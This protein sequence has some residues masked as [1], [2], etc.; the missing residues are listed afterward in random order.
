MSDAGNASMARLMQGATPIMGYGTI[1]R[2]T[3][4]TKDFDVAVNGAI[5]KC[6]MSGLAD[7]Y[8]GAGETAMPYEGAVVLAVKP[9]S[10]ASVGVI[11][12]VIPKISY[13][14]GSIA[15]PIIPRMGLENG[16]SLDDESINGILGDSSYPKTIAASGRPL[17]ALPGEHHVTTADFGTHQSVAGP[18]VAM[19]ASEMASVRVSAIDD[20]VQIKADTLQEFK[21]TGDASTYDDG[22]LT[23][24]EEEVC[25]YKHER[26]GVET[27]EAPS[28]VKATVN[29]LKG[30][31]TSWKK[32]SNDL[33]ARSRLRIFKGYLGDIFHAFVCIPGEN[34]RGAAN[35]TAGVF[36]THV[37]SDGRLTIKTAAGLSIQRNDAIPVPKRKRMPWDPEGDRAHEK[38]MVSAR[39]G[40]FQ[41]K[42]DTKSLEL[43][44]AEAWRGS[45]AYENFVRC[46]PEDFT[47]APE[48]STPAPKNAY[49]LTSKRMAEFEAFMR[50]FA[51]FNIEADGS[52]IIQGGEGCEFVMAKGQI[53]MHA[54]KGIFGT[55]GKD[56]VMLAGNDMV[57]KSKNSADII[58]TKADVR[59]KAENNLHLL[60]ASEQRGNVILQSNAKGEVS[61]NNAKGT[62]HVGKG[63]IIQTTDSG[64]GVFTKDVTAKVSNDVTVRAEKEL[65]LSSGGMLHA[66]GRTLTITDGTGG[67][68]VASGTVRIGGRS[69]TCMADQSFT[70]FQ[71][72]SRLRTEWGTAPG[73]YEAPYSGY[74]ASITP[75]FKIWSD[76]V[77]ILPGVKADPRF[78]YRN[79][80]DST[81]TTAIPVPEWSK[82]SKFYGVSPV[83][84]W[85]EKSLDSTW[86]WPGQAAYET[87]NLL[88]ITGDSNILADAWDKI[89]A[90]D[91]NLDSPKKFSEYPTL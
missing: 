70:A 48:G 81:M 19:A 34:T 37:G 10:T 88:S 12:A 91:G 5:W 14:R 90:E 15:A 11:I 87:G 59:I 3:A 69:I 75:L 41:Y 66:S 78:S 46:F 32:V 16:A 18:V 65:G 9:M 43:R 63:V 44:N 7:P 86:P 64:L 56:I 24:S 72:T 25:L 36:S 17:D 50:K 58:S 67:L 84:S 21:A 22:G 71:H 4:A 76:P 60:G 20:S 61:T 30:F 31:V 77:S 51:A 68:D 47:V 89:T 2:A 27:L 52:V 49:D 85:E 1:V 53:T 62:D 29:I 74:V 33:T 39:P 8:A 55:S 26:L 6:I 79:N 38:D 54:P 80:Y 42:G 57:L 83:R 23:S 28:F 73:V 40:P 45:R 82:N 13:E 35:A